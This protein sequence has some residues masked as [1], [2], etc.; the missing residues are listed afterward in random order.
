MITGA[1]IL[2]YSPAADEVRKF[3][4]DVLGFPATPAGDGWPIFA[5]PPAELAVHPTEG[6]SRHELY[7]MCD[8]LESTMAELAAKGVQ[9]GPVSEQRWGRLTSVPLPGGGEVGLYEP[10]HPTAISPSP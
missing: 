5:M 10:S 2:I 7:L 4:A 1:H 9:C 8:D 3:I 6:D